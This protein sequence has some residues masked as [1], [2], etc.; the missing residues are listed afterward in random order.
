MKIEYW[1]SLTS[2]FF[3]GYQNLASVNSS[4]IALASQLHKPGTQMAT[5]IKVE[6]TV[7][8][9]SGMTIQLSSQLL[10]WLNNEANLDSEKRKRIKLPVV[11][12]FDDSYRLALGDSFIGTSNQDRH[13]ETIFLSPNDAGMGISL[14]SR[15]NNLCPKTVN[16]CVVW[17]EGYWGSRI[18]SNVPELSEQEK[19]E[20]QKWPFAVMAIG[21][22]I[23]EEAKQDEEIRILVESSPH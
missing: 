1:I 15:L 14:L 3:L 22:L 18:D 17:L 20:E 11:V 2:I 13:H 10:D 6:K 21:E 12:H 8:F 23:Q 19:N 9:T 7:D 4:S 16:H 5:S